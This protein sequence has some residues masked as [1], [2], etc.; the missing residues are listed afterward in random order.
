M[1]DGSW[2]W[3]HMDN[4]LLHLIV[5]F[6]VFLIGRKLK[7]NL[8]ATCLLAILF[9]IHPM[10]VESVAWLTER[11]DVLFA[12]FYFAALYYYIK[13]KLKG[14]EWKYLFI[15]IPLFL[16]SGLSK[17]QAVS[18]PLTMI[19]VDY[20]IDRKFDIGKMIKKWPYFLISLIIGLTGTYILSQ[21]GVI[22]DASNAE[23]NGGHRLVF[24]L[25]AY[26]QYIAKAVY[27]W[28][29]S[30]LYPYP[31]NFDSFY[32][33]GPVLFL[34]LAA[35]TFWAYKKDKFAIVFGILFFTVNIVFVLQIV[36]AGQGLFA[37]RFT[38]V[39]YFGLF[40]IAAYYFGKLDFKKMAGKITLGAVALYVLFLGYKTYIQT[41]IWSNSYSM[42][43]HVIQYYPKTKV[44]WGNRANWLRDN[45]YTQQA[46]ADYTER[47]RIADDD[48]E[49]FNSRGK[50]YFQS[51]KR[52]TLLFA[53]ADYKEAVRLAEFK[54]KKKELQAEYRV[55]LASTYARLGQNREA[56]DMF[57]EA[58]TFNPNN[59]NVYFNRSITLHNIGDY[60]AEQRDIIKYLEFKPRDGAMIS[61]LGTTKRLLGDYVGA[62]ADFNR[63]L[64]YSSIPAIFMERARNYI[65]LG[66]LAEARK[67]V[68]TL[69]QNGFQ[70]PGDILQQTGM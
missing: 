35:G 30:P 70:V 40:F 37:D 31:A 53:L 41:D 58:Q 44:T 26:V 11:K 62:E 33:A 46:L 7:L 63:A 21:S 25:Y 24:G 8:Y 14:N 28:I 45:G 9:G 64:K 47:I 29:M 19:V 18:L 13:G 22:L 59:V 38:Y 48:P 3:W 10:R 55:N 15:I 65:A 49:P 1:E 6:F 61:N 50:L 67:D 42:W 34:L 2:K 52:D 56:I 23:Y 20:F 57:T 27:P 43:S 32:L 4:I 66:K 69:Q 68:Q 5:V 16:L 17:I 12:S 39:P 54:K 36:G 51:Q 60:V